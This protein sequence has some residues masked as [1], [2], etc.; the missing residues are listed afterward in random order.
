MLY[1]LFPTAVTNTGGAVQVMKC[2]K[3]AL[4]W[5]HAAQQQAHAA[6]KASD[7]EPVTLFVEILNLYAYY[8]DQGLKTITANVL[9]AC[10]L[11]CHGC[12]TPSI[13]L[14]VS[15]ALSLPYSH[16]AR[17]WLRCCGCAERDRACGQP[18]GG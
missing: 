18:H 10:V 11:C 8:F 9:Q 15:L 6:L 5:A 13:V 2:L 16:V 4:K 17:L 14:V 12:K 3:R 1:C 7:V